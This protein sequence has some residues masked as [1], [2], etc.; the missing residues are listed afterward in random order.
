MARWCATAARGTLRDET[1]AVV[2][3]DARLASGSMDCT[4][5]LWKS[6]QPNGAPRMLFMAEAAIN[7]LA[8]LPGLQPLVEAMAE[9]G[10]R[11]WRWEASIPDWFRTWRFSEHQED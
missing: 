8:W 11:G 4:I 3:G 5:R 9:A 6:H 7:A 2:L 10:C 1:P